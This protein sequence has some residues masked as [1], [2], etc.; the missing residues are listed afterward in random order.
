M[1]KL[2][3]KINCLKETLNTKKKLQIQKRNFK[4]KK[5]TSNTKKKI[6]IL[7]NLCCLF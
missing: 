3:E 4:Y 6:E 1:P 2:K 5:E 7:T